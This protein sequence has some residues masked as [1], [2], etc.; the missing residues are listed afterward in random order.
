[1]SGEGSGFNRQKKTA[2]FGNGSKKLSW[3]MFI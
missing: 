2:A 1:M 3:T